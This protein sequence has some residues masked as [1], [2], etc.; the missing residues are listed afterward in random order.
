MIAKKHEIEYKT[1][2]AVC[3]KEH[4]GKTFEDGPICFTAST[5]FYS[6]ENITE[7]QLEKMLQEADSINLFGNKCVDIAIKKG[8]AS[9]KSVKII[10]GIKHTQIYRV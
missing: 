8:F 1:I 3:D 6:G 7:E 10:A 2:L 4:I 5:K 9:E